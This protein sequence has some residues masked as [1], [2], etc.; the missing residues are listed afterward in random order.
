MFRIL[1]ILA[2]AL[3]LPT[4][5]HAAL[6][7][8]PA[9]AVADLAEST[10][11]YRAEVEPSVAWNGD[12]GLVVWRARVQ[13]NDYVLA[14][15]LD[16]TGMPLEPRPMILSREGTSSF[17]RVVPLGSGFLVVWQA[18]LDNG[19]PL[20]GVLVDREGAIRQVADLA[21][22]PFHPNDVASNG[23]T[24]LITGNSGDPDFRSSLIW[25]DVQGNV[26]AR[27]TFGGTIMVTT[28]VRSNGTSFFVVA[29][30]LVCAT[31]TCDHTFSLV[32]AGA[33]GTSMEPR[34]LRHVAD[35]QSFDYA[36]SGISV[37]RDRVLAVFQEPRGVMTGMLFDHD[38]H[39][40]A[41]PF[42]LDDPGSTGLAVESDGQSFVVATPHVA[43]DGPAAP[44]RTT[45]LRRIAAS[46]A[47]EPE[48]LADDTLDVALAWT[49]SGYL[50]ARSGGLT[51]ASESMNVSVTRLPP[52]GQHDPGAPDYVVSR[53]PNQQDAPA[54][55]WNGSRLFTAWE[56]YFPSEG[57]WRVKYGR[58]DAAGNPLD[59]RGRI[60]AASGAQQRNPRVVFD[61][62]RFLVLWA[63]GSA[64][65]TEI[66]A[67]RVNADGS[68]A[69][70]P[71]IVAPSSCG[72]DFSAA[73]DGNRVLVAHLGG[74]CDTTQFRSVLVTFVEMS[75]TASPSIAVAEQILA[76]PPAIAVGDANALLVWTQSVQRAPSDPCPS[77]Y[78][79]CPP[80]QVLG[81]AVVENGTSRRV[82]VAEDGMML[83]REPQLAWDGQNYLVVWAAAPDLQ[84][85]YQLRTRTFS[86]DGEPSAQA[87]VL[88]AT[89]QPTYS[90]ERHGSVTATPSGFLVAW[91]RTAWLNTLSLWRVAT[92]GTPIDLVEQPVETGVSDLRAPQLVRGPGTTSFLLYSLS[93]PD[94]I[95]LGHNRIVSRPI[96]ETVRGR[97]VR[98]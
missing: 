72:A 17:S 70:E 63:E 77:L 39:V 81:A 75:D 1:P 9:R 67:R 47:T 89:A 62:S 95:Y 23:S 57:V 28:R 2:L 91:Q 37:S 20:R 24:V 45:R 12:R 78:E 65:M 16:S 84:N 35:A 90:A 5:G 79:Y 68:P 44:V 87:H 26:F 21:S 33:D 18:F 97:A 19:A 55:A 66:R 92:S 4:R 73:R 82:A 30:Q 93:G 7:A 42:P 11:A 53:A 88:S 51:G 14:I 10:G 36:L 58:S 86:R 80:K 8:G 83:N 60:V 59:G 27:R 64:T 34:V 71:F 29:D 22:S 96:G 76:E 13:Q 41:G 31:Y 74:E 98:H 25:L 94:E 85:V 49:G 50:L 43:F 56:E 69:G 61:G 38:G 48:V 54:A 52:N 32:Q 46:G 3:L 15:H 6:V 40:D